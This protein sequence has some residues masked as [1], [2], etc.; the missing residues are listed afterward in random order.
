MTAELE[1]INGD[2][3]EPCS[4]QR[5]LIVDKNTTVFTGNPLHICNIQ[6]TLALDTQVLIHI[7]SYS[8]AS[9]FINVEREGDLLRG[10]NRYVAISGDERCFI[11]LFHQRIRLFL[12]GNISVSISEI[13]AGNLSS[14]GSEG[15]E[16]THLYTG[17]SHKKLCSF[18]EYNVTVTCIQNQDQV[19]SFDF[20]THC[21]AILETSSVTF[22][23]LGDKYTA[24]IFHSDDFDELN[25]EGHNIIQV[26]G[27]PF[28]HFPMLK[29]LIFDHNVLSFLPVEVF[30]NLNF[31]AHLSL[32]GN[33]LATISATIFRSLENLNYLSLR[34]NR[35]S[36]LDVAVF[37]GL[38]KLN[39]LSLRGNNLAT[40]EEE[41][42]DATSELKQLDLSYSKLTVLPSGLFEGLVKL[43]SLE[44]KHN[45]LIE[46]PSA[47]LQ[48]ATNL[49]TLKCSNNRLAV[50][51]E[52]T[53]NVTKNLVYLT[54][55]Q[56][57]LTK[58][59][60]RLFDGLT[61]LETLKLSDNLIT[62]LHEDMFTGTKNLVYLTM[63]QNRLTKLPK[64]LFKGLTK[65]KTLKLSN[66]PANTKRFQNVSYWFQFGFV[67]IK[68]SI[69]VLNTLS[70]ILIDDGF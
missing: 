50:L 69:S 40:L 11:E 54:M 17:V 33:T 9:D 30:G 65:L 24:F 19:C 5:E 1:I 55:Y 23:C 43:E 39:Y 35:L 36:S 64:G 10:Q 25:L 20:P 16:K 22:T 61:K 34:D 70:K 29:S 27:Y 52:N 13:S 12:R 48:D 49:K 37:K 56:N 62:D 4:L 45:H 59:P 58:L 28:Q 60:K 32:R 3:F 21:N 15:K 68:R 14:I 41:S 31:L 26:N 7:P 66:N 67:F 6:L 8:S 18:T 51:H 42:F 57:K 47:L 46:L 44:I 63:Y 2:V 38:T 53:F